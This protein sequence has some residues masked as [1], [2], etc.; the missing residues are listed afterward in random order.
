MCIF[1]K[2]KH[3]K[4]TSNKQ[5]R[6]FTIYANGNKYRSNPCSLTEFQDRQYWSEN[7]WKEFLNN[8]KDYYVVRKFKG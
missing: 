3:M 1:A 6:T 7:D 8:S 4:I 5:F 2:I